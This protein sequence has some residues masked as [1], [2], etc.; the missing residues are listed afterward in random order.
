MHHPRTGTWRRRG[1]TA[2]ALGVLA[3]GV[4][5]ARAEPWSERSLFASPRFEQVWRSADLAV[6]QGQTNRSWTWGPQPWFDYMEFYRQ[7]PNGLRQV[8][9]FDKARMEINNPANTSGPL[10]GVTNGLLPVELVSGR[11]KLGDGT[12]P[13]QNEQREPAQIPVAGDPPTVNP[14]APTYASFRNVATTDNGY[15]DPN[16]VGQRAG[17]TFDKNGAVGFR[18]D[19]A[20]QPGTELVVYETV[21]G[22]NVPRVFN[23]FRN[24]GPVAAIFAFGYPITDPYWIRARVGGVEK[25]V[26]VQIFERRVLT[27]TPS[28]PA[29]FQVEMGNVG[30]HYFQWRYPHLGHP[31]FAADPGLPIFFGSKRST[32]EFN[33]YA[34]DQSGN[35]QTALSPGEKESLPFSVLRSWDG[36][37]VRLIGDSKRYNDKRQLISIKPYG[38]VS[39]T[40]LHTSNANDYNAS[41]SPDGTKIAFVSDRDGNPELY[42]LNIGSTAEPTRLTDTIGCINQYPTWLP[43]GSGLVY[44][45]NCQGGNFEIYRASLSYGQDMLN[46]LT[47]TRLISPVPNESTR[48]T[49]NTTDDRYPRVSPDGRLIAFTATRDGNPEIY[50][51]TIDGGQQTRRTSSNG[52]DLAPSWAPNNLQLVFSSNRDGDFE[53]Y[54]MNVDGSNQ[55]QLTNNGQADQWPIWAQ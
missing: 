1:I 48:L 13:D 39:T 12:G 8:Q 34:M 7:S 32:A 54:S 46:E 10:G 2:L 51:M 28:N 53:I 11:V 22:H 37:E 16:R 25:D 50:T 47:V 5:P 29:N 17:W 30:Q 14:D 3:A 55:V 40:R 21:T 38:T 42:L 24:A 35:N 45:S 20:N 6:Q 19:L 44:E 31:W 9:Y 52:E 18:Q 15:R 27:Y 33:I 43:D 4:V 23:D 41:V 26:L 49:N 36:D